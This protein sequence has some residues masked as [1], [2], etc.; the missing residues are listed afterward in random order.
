[1][2]L[3]LS[4]IRQRLAPPVDR[5]TII[6]IMA[7]GV[8]V[9]PQLKSMAYIL[10]NTMPQPEIDRLAGLALHAVDLM[11]AG[12]KKGLNQFLAECNIPPQIRSVINQYASNITKK[13]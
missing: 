7:A 11:D 1:M 8:N 9:P 10:L 4:L 12:D 2:S 3:D 13:Q 5:A 6:E